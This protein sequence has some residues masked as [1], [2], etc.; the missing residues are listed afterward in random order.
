MARSRLL[1]AGASM[2]V[3]LG[4][5]GIAPPASAGS[6]PPGFFGV[7]PQGPLGGRDFERMKGTVGTLRLPIVWAQVEPR[8][9]EYD[10]DS[11]DQTVV[12]AARR[13]V[14]VLPFVYATPAWISG[15]P[16]RPPLGTA[17]ARQ[18]WSSF[19][20]V[21]VRRYGPQGIVWRNAPR[22]QPI[23]SWQIWNEPNF[24]IFWHPHTSPDGYARLLKLSATAIRAAD[25]G[26]R[27]VLAG[28]APVGAGP[29]PWVFLRRLYRVPG[30]RAD[31]DV[32]AVHPYS[33]T[34][35]GTAEQIR[36]AR[37]VMDSAGDGGKSLLVSELGVASWGDVP[38]A[39]VKGRRGQE[40]FLR[41]AFARLVGRRRAWHLVG[42]DWF[43]WQDQTQV[44]PKCAFRQGAGLFDLE[45]RAKP[46]W[47]AYRR[48]V[49]EARVR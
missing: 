46:V 12:G 42:V 47:W 41:R 34:V 21:L 22:G 27:I 4:L 17:G 45:G 5:L 32:A 43:A 36:A 13:G 48:A 28:V 38:S 31:F 30:V 19:L 11:L 3:V 37:Q 33:A 24:R 14:R 8:S 23:R 29:L 15:D 25:R 39:F 2:A 49:G 1:G 16:M 44:D 10:F 6:V 26:A 7:V 9:G 40:D 35:Q 18:A 20:R